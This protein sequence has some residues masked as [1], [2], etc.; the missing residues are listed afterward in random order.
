MICLLKLFTYKNMQLEGAVFL[1]LIQSTFT[2]N[3]Y[4]NN[5]IIIS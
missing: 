5:I 4:I 1:K 3:L 2:L